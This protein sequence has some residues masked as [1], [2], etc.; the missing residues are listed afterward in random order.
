MMCMM[1]RNFW[2]MACG[3][4]YVCHPLPH[5]NFECGG[6]LMPWIVHIFCQNHSIKRLGG[7]VNGRVTCKAVHDEIRLILFFGERRSP[8]GSFSLPRNIC[9]KDVIFFY[10]WPHIKIS[11]IG[12]RASSNPCPARPC[13]CEASRRA[14]HPN[15]HV[16]VPKTPLPVGRCTAVS[17]E[18]A[19]DHKGNL[20]LTSCSLS[21]CDCC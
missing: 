20:Y 6:N 8:L 15:S 1:F 14:P 19:R 11:R 5:K 3:T 4:R 21:S 13:S 18:F 12:C 17:C 10:E 2:S 16:R 9:V 7:H